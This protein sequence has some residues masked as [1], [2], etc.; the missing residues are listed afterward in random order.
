MKESN[1]EVRKTK[2]KGKGLFSRKKLKKGE[3]I[4]SVDL[5]NEKSHSKE[6][7][8]NNPDLQSDHCDYI[9]N[10]K[11]VI[12]FHPYSYMNHSC[13]PNVLID[14][15]SMTKSE[16]YAMKDIDKGN[17]LKYDYGANAL[18]GFDKDSG[19]WKKMKCNCESE[20]C[21][22]I[23][24]SDFFKLPKELQKRYWKYLPPKIKKK[25]KNKFERLK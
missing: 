10:N 6:E 18:S 11:Y 14:H 19:G 22:K 12:S 1:V 7:I 16:F 5:S 4:F 13:N 3:L 9:G 17:E 2:D 23:I 15:K 25:H 24:Y 21:R 20:N 8:E